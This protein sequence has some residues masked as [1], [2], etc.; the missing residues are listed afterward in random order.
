MI[1]KYLLVLLFFI[2]LS[3]ILF[4][5]FSFTKSKQGKYIK[6]K[7]D[8]KE[9]ETKLGDSYQELID[10]YDLNPSN[11]LNGEAILYDQQVIQTD[12]S[13]NKISI[14]KASYEELITLPGIGDKIALRIIE[15]RNTYGFWAIEDLKNVKGIG[16]K[17]YEKLKEYL[18]I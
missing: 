18:A 3:F 14:N 13:Q 10:E 7:V 15:Y 8:D 6:V 1:K 12:T 2:L 16:E 9:Y 4:N 11:N 17:K 5:S